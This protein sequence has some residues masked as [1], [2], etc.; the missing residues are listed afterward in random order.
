MNTFFP[1]RE[2]PE[3][4]FGV[5]GDPVAHSLSPRMH[6]AAYAALG[7]PYRYVAIHVHPGQVAPALARLTSLGYQGINATV[8]H[9][10]EALAWATE[11]DLFAKHARAAN[12]LRLADRACTNTDSPGFLDTLVEFDPPRR[13]ALIL[14]AGGS[15][16][17]V[18]VALYAAGYEL[19]LYNRTREKA[20]ALAAELR[21]ATDRVRAAADPTRASLI[22]N[23][24]SASLHN[25]ELP[26]MW[27][28]AEAGALAYDLMYGKELT[29]FLRRA[30][31][32]GL[33]T[34][35]GR[36]MLVAQ[37]ARAF[38]WWLGIEPPRDVMLEAIQ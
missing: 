20:E 14:G 17:A 31:D 23:T 24:T 5:I 36:A 22:V 33:A 38:K 9:K 12:T 18:A 30:A 15:A 3:A 27:E 7:L 26:I 13:T 29:P 8:P 6:G 28:N 4:E 2:A 16:R 32:H 37:G 11:A 10:E 34:I 21:L 19:Y 35:D 1:W 25:E